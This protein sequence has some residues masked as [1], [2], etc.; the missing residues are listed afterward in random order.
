MGERLI[1]FLAV[2]LHD[3]LQVVLAQVQ[4]VGSLHVGI[5]QSVELLT[6]LYDEALADQRHIAQL[7]LN[8]LG[9]DVLAVGA[10]EHCL[11]ASLDE[12]VAFCI[13]DAEVARVV[14]TVLV[15]GCLR[16][17]GVLEVAQHDVGTLGQDFACHVL[18]VTAV[19]AYLHVLGGLSAT[20]LLEVLPVLVG[21]DGSTLRGT[22]AHRVVETYILEQ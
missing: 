5:N 21:D 9:V 8:L 4:F 7:V 2:L 22:I 16:G 12:D 1:Q 13:H 3:G 19:D 20:G 18:R 17:L 11:A 10:Q 15:D 6:L 14:P